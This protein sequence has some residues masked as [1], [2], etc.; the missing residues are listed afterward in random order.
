MVYPRFGEDLLGDEYDYEYDHV[1][2]M[3]HQGVTICEHCLQEFCVTE[4]FP[5]TYLADWRTSGEEKE[6]VLGDGVRLPLDNR[7]IRRYLYC[8][9]LIHSEWA[10]LERNVCVELP[11]CALLEIRK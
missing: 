2:Q 5:E 11:K 10:P 1:A 6:V 8:A 7:G 4:D 9:F 3:A